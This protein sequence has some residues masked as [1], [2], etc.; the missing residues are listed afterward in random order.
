[1]GMGLCLLWGYVNGPLGGA[2]KTTSRACH[3]LC[4][5]T[6]HNSHDSAIFIPKLF[7]QTINKPGGQPKQ[8]HPTVEALA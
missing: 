3:V 1:M 6:S 8:D 2:K 4:A 7:K 5:P